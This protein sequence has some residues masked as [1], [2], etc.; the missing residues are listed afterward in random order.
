[1]LALVDDAVLKNCAAKDM[2]GATEP[3]EQAALGD[4]VVAG[5]CQRDGH[6]QNANSESRIQMVH[7]GCFRPYRPGKSTG[8]GSAEKHYQCSA[9]WSG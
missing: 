7:P 2:A 6:G 3:S 8:G 5:R 1:M 4:G 9:A